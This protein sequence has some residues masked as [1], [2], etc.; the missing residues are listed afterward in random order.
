MRYKKLP[1]IMLLLHVLSCN[2]ADLARLFKNV[3]PGK[4]RRTI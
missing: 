1:L 4:D 3:E 2:A